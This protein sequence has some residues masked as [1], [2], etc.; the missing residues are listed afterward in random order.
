MSNS[1]VG[2][3]DPSPGLSSFA[4]RVLLS[5]LPIASCLIYTILSNKEIKG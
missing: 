5:L 4:C 1:L 2:S 3:A